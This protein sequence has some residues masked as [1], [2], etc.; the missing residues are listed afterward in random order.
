MDIVEVI[1]RTNEHG[2]P[3]RMFTSPG[4]ERG[5]RS[6]LQELPVPW[7]VLV[8]LARPQKPASRNGHAREAYCPTSGHSLRSGNKGSGRQARR[9]GAMGVLAGTPGRPSTGA[10][11]TS[12]P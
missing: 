7:S 4:E 8:V 11:N 12:A 10:V 1:Q 9:G 3:N 5:R 2:E 6:A